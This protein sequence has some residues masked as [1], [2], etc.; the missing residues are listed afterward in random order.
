MD[1]EETDFQSTP[2]SWSSKKFIRRV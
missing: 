2:R 1:V